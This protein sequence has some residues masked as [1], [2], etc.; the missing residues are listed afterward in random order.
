MSSAHF[1]D[2]KKDVESLNFVSYKSNSP[3]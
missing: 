1:E 2:F 3:S